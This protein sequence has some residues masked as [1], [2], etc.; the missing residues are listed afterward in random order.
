[1]KNKK[2][3]ALLTTLLA[4]ALNAATG[5]IEWKHKEMPVEI[6]RG[7]RSVEVSFPFVI[8]SSEPVG[9]ISTKTSSPRVTVDAGIVGEHKPGA[10]GVLKAR[11]V[12][13]KDGFA[14]TVEKITVQIADSKTPEVELRLLVRPT[15]AYRVEP[16]YALWHVGA[17]P[18]AKDL[19]FTDITGKGCKPVIVYSTSI[20]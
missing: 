15:L 2:S 1:M 11:Y 12:P 9:I 17:D 7:Q 6:R 18:I 20:L 13:G 16:R 3:I 10:E 4:T 19:Y 8:T 5:G 14:N